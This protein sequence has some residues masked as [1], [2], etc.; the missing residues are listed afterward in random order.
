[1]NISAQPVAFIVQV[2]DD[3]L[4]QRLPIDGPD[5]SIGRDLDNR[6]ALAEDRTA[7]R[8][9]CVIRVTGQ[10]LVVEDLKSTN[11]T[12]VD[13]KRIEG[14][15]SL[16]PPCS[17][18]VGHTQLAIV[19]NP[20]RASDEIEVAFANLYTGPDSIIIPATAFFHSSDFVHSEAFLVVDLVDS[21]RLVQQSDGRFAKY[22]YALGKTIQHDLHDYPDKYL[23]GTGDGFF[24]CF[25]N[26]ASALDSAIRLGSRL[27]YLV[28]P[29][30]SVPPIQ[31]SVALHFGEAVR[32]QTPAEG[33]IGDRTGRHVHGVFSL[34]KVRHE[35]FELEE[36]IRTRQI[37]ELVLMTEDFL[38]KLAT[39]QQALTAFC[40]TYHLKGF[41]ENV[42]VYRWIGPS[43]SVLGERPKP[44][45]SVHP[46]GPLNS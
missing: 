32:A 22:M 41:E 19:A 23:K 17:L 30:Q 35:N 44:A 1:V 46:P 18:M 39:E 45:A 25:P 29:S 24:A 31:L 7:S 42:R 14:S 27:N 33:T 10:R 3:R 13:G 12:F 20:E 2:G 11:G 34:E 16:K 43:L 21:T 8:H 28:N 6:L 4:E 36:A 26:A 40:G 5:F 9:H 15:A 37:S 38:S